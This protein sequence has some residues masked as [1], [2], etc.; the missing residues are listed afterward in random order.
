M[1]RIWG[2]L[3]LLSV[4]LHAEKE[5]PLEEGGWISFLHK[6]R[7]K[8]KGKPLRLPKNFRFRAD[9]LPVKR[10]RVQDA[11]LAW[12]WGF[13]TGIRCDSKLHQWHAMAGYTHFHSGAF[14]SAES[15]EGTLLPLLQKALKGSSW[16]ES[17]EASWRLHLDLADVEVGKILQRTRSFFLRP[18]V[19]LRSA[20]IHQKTEMSRVR[21]SMPVFLTNYYLGMGLRSGIDSLWTLRKGLHFFGDTALS[22]LAGYYNIHERQRWIRTDP[23]L[24]KDPNAPRMGIAGAEASF[25]LS[26]EKSFLKQKTV[27]SARLGYEMNYF[28]NHS[29]WLNQFSAFE[30]DSPLGGLPMQAL[31]A[32]LSLAF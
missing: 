13:R 22:Y 1:K 17:S 8:M 14:S 11:R 19:G 2:C 12:S 5:L 29:R 26:Y 7:A 20:W 32:G 18:H 16:Q 28:F 9:K 15:Q 4:S 6:Q 3:L 10:G 25:G 30:G 24:L 23:S 27:F 31:T 21:K